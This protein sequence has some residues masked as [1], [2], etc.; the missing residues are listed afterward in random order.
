MCFYGHLC[1][2]Y[3]FWWR[4]WIQVHTL[5][6]QK[7]KEKPGGEQIVTQED[8]PWILTMSLNNAF[9]VFQKSCLLFFRANI[10]RNNSKICWEQHKIFSAWFCGSSRN[11]LKAFCCV[12]PAKD[13]LFTLK[14]ASFRISKK[15]HHH[16]AMQEKYSIKPPLSSQTSLPECV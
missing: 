13:R 16:K 1:T 10:Y 12:P 14:T 4:N 3:I 5:F 2:C 11:F 9:K 8:I 15:I 6:C 7:L